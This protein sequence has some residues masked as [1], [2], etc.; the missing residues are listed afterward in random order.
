MA[1]VYVTNPSV[2]ISTNAAAPI[3]TENNGPIIV[4]GG[5]YI[6]EATLFSGAVTSGVVNNYYFDLPS[7]N[8][9]TYSVL[10]NVSCTVLLGSVYSSSVVAGT[11]LAPSTTGS[12][13]SLLPCIATPTLGQSTQPVVSIATIVPLVTT[14][15]TPSTLFL[16][17]GTPSV[18]IC[19]VAQNT[20]TLTINLVVSLVR[21]Q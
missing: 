7:L 18:C 6:S 20:T 13:S 2:L 16:F 21:V 11:H 15:V 19:C 9:G 10:L 14:G 1:G 4:P 3:A 5:Q 12:S 17:S 8:A